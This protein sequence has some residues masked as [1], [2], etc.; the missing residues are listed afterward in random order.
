MAKNFM[1]VPHNEGQELNYIE[2]YSGN[3][4]GAVQRATNMLV[5][6]KAALRQGTISVE[7]LDS[8]AKK[9][10]EVV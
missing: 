4:S 6:L 9:V 5:A 8:N 10:R 7:V 2:D 1:I 3:L